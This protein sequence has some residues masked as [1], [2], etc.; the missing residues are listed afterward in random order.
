M[1]TYYT[2]SDVFL[3]PQITSCNSRSSLNTSS[4]IGTIELD[5]PIISSNM[6]TITGPEMAIAMFQAG[7]VGALH[8]FVSTDQAVEDY[9]QVKSA[10]ADCFVSLGVNESD[11]QRAFALHSAG[12]RNFIIDIA[13]GHSTMM[14]HMLKI[15]RNTFGFGEDI[16]IVAGN[17]ATPEAVRDLAEWGADCIKVGIGGGS[18]C[19]TRV[20]TG[21]GVPM[22]SCLVECCEEADKLGVEIIADGGIKT[23]GDAVKALAAGSDFVM[24]GSIFSG[25]PETP[26]EVISTGGKDYKVFRGMASVSAMT[27]RNNREIDDLPVG[28]G[29]KTTV[30]LKPPVKNIVK[31]MQAGIRSGMSYMGAEKLS[32][33][34]IVSKW[35]VQTSSGH[36]EGTPHILNTES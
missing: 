29:V 9:N 32:D 18:C 8:R 24:A 19:S 6:D 27:D 5:V 22:F 34:S 1:K 30:P 36:F 15:M 23:S 13:H 4:R 26:G 10:G 7:G 25:S 2:F 35:G 20:I 33:M 17:V 3:I 11:I 16:Y 21:H 12:A 14:R 28:E 31:D